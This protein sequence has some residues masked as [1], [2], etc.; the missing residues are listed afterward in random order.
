MTFLSSSYKTTNHIDLMTKSERDRKKRHAE[1]R[2]SQLRSSGD[3]SSHD[4]L[5]QMMILNSINTATVTPDPGTPAHG[6]DCGGHSHSC[7]SHSSC[8]SSSSCAS[9]GG[10]ASCG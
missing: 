5:T 3:T 9:A 1:E 8:A 4:Y 2:I 7:S 6:G 10:C